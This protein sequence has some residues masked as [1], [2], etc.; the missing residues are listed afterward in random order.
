V[1]LC[2]SP[3]LAAGVLGWRRRIELDEGLART[4]AGEQLMC[5]KAG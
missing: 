1:E 2:S 3:D 5:T 4:I